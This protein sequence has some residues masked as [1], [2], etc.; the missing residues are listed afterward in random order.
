MTSVPNEKNPWSKTGGGQVTTGPL[1]RV[2][3]MDATIS[4]DLGP[5]PRRRPLV[6]SGVGGRQGAW[7][8]TTGTTSRDGPPA[9]LRWPDPVRR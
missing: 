7:Q 9:G 4:G 6:L 5:V 3:A 1:G 8:G 2:T